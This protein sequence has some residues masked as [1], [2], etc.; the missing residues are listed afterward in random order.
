MSATFVDA[1]DLELSADG[2]T[3]EEIKKMRET[4]NANIATVLMA[5]GKKDNEYK[6]FIC[7]CKTSAKKHA[8]LWPCLHKQ[9]C[10]DCAQYSPARCPL[11]NQNIRSIIIVDDVN[12]DVP[13]HRDEDLVHRCAL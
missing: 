12:K 11:C 6:C 8:I 2:Y 3:L 7:M 5:L 13:S 10:S 9:F 1:K 4:L